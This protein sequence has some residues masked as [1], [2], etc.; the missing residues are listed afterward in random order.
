MSARTTCVGTLAEFAKEKIKEKEKMTTERRTGEYHVA[1]QENKYAKRLYFVAF[2]SAKPLTKVLNRWSNSAIA[3]VTLEPMIK[4]HVFWEWS[5]WPY[6]LKWD[7]GSQI[8]VESW[9]R[10]LTGFHNISNRIRKVLGFEESHKDW[11]EPEG[12]DKE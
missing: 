9:E 7:T 1:V 5:K 4:D 6:M 3:E 2:V 8:P 10:G 12:D 11:L